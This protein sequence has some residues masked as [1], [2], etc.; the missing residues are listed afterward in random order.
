MRDLLEVS[1]D[2]AA[3]RDEEELSAALARGMERLFP[4][5]NF[6]IRL[7]DPKTLALTSLF[8]RGRLRPSARERISLRRSAI[9]KTGLSEATLEAAGLGVVDADEP[10]F[11]GCD[12]VNAVPLAASGALYGVVNLEYD[13]GTSGNPEADEPILLQVAN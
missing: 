5:R 12:R 4:G 7:T 10:V 13:S 6:C 11:E 2:V 3:A 1:R 9:R 8:S